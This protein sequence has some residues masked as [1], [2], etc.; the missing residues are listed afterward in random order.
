MEQVPTELRTRTLRREDGSEEQVQA[1]PHHSVDVDA[2]LN[3][4]S[5]RRPGSCCAM[6][7]GVQIFTRLVA[8]GHEG[9]QVHA[10][11]V[12]FFRYHHTAVQAVAPRN[13]SRPLQEYMELPPSDYQLLQVAGD[14]DCE[15]GTVLLN[16]TLLKMHF[17]PVHFLY[18]N[19][20]RSYLPARRY[21]YGAEIVPSA[22]PHPAGGEYPATS[23]DRGLFE[24]RDG[25]GRGL[26][27]AGD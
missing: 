26:Q 24:R 5:V 7:H 1:P 13:A 2:F 25:C 18:L 19:R 14:A 9:Q 17:A 16:A 3:K 11:Q 21:P 27:H 15:E 10:S 4:T 8:Q 6:C 20:R 22:P 12:L 23:S